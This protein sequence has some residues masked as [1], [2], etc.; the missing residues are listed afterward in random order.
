MALNDLLDRLFL[1]CIRMEYLDPPV[2]KTIPT[3]RNC[4]S[5]AR[6]R[7]STYDKSAADDTNSRCTE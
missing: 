6:S 4:G 1:L 5:H 7:H 3:K 2:D